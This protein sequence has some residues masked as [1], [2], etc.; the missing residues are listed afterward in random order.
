MKVLLID[1]YDSYT[2]ILSHTIWK[3][4]GH[5]PI[6]IKNNAFTV[7]DLRTLEFNAIV[8]S[9]GPGHPSLQDDF[10]QCLAVLQAFKQIPILGICLGHQG[11]GL[12][13]GSLVVEAPE[14][15]HGKLSTLNHSGTFLFAG[16]ASQIKVMR[17]HSLVIEDSE[18]KNLEVLAR[19]TEDQQIMA[20]RHRKYPYFGLQFHPESIGTPEGETLL[21]NFFSFAG[22]W[23]LEKGMNKK[24]KASHELQYRKIAWREP[25]L[26]FEK[27]YE[28]DDYSFWL[29]SNSHFGKTDYSVMGRAHKIFKVFGECVQCMDSS[30]NILS[31][32]N[33]ASYSFLREALEEVELGGLEYPFPYSSGLFGYMGYEWGNT[34]GIKGSKKDNCSEFPDAVFLKPEKHLIFDHLKKEI[35]VVGLSKKGEPLSEAL[36]QLEQTVLSVRQDGESEAIPQEHDPVEMEE[37]KAQFCKKEYLQLIEQIKNSI[38]KRG[39][40]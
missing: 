9:P 25:L 4:T 37:G 21:K 8:I 35:Y 26:V 38:K 6:I 2:H 20:I 17:Y 15:K 32:E 29:D 19:S 22:N 16:V 10:G 27:L 30:S 36:E 31:K 12:F 14:V 13:S 23:N 33:Q 39:H 7:E 3:I 28:N 34:D 24:S 18:N 40:L 11:I 5:Q 1:N